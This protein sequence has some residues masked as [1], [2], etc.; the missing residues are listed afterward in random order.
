MLFSDFLISALGDPTQRDTGNTALRCLRFWGFKKWEWVSASNVSSDQR[1]NNPFEMQSLPLPIKHHLWTKFDENIV[2]CQT[3]V[4]MN[5]LLHF[6]S[7][8]WKDELSLF[9]SSSECR[10][11]NYPLW[12]NWFMFRMWKDKW[13]NI[14]IRIQTF[15]H[16]TVYL[17]R[18]N[19]L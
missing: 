12:F 15:N 10:R 18:L 6:M 8:I 16:G 7:R 14:T 3:A 2:F 4:L 5:Y 13:K 1:M 9:S 19:M 11:M 17:R